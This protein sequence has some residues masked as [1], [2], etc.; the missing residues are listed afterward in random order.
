[1]EEIIRLNKS[2]CK[3]CY[4]CIRNCPVKSIAYRDEQIRIISDECIYCGN[5][6]LVCPQNAKS[7]N[8]D[9]PK[10]KRALQAGEKLYVSLAPSYVAAFPQSG[11][12]KMSAALKALGF[13]HVEETAIGAEQ[14]TRE[15]EKLIQKHRMK[16]I[17]TTACPSVNLLIEKNYPSLIPQMAPVVTPVI[18]HSHMIKK[19][20]GVRAKVVF[21]GPCISKKYECSDP[22]NNH[23]LFAVLTF[24]ELDQ[25]FREEGIDFAK[26][27]RSA[28]ALVN[29]LPRYY[30]TPGGII[31]NLHRDSRRA[32][33]CLSI[34]GVDRCINILDSVV[35]DDL[36]GYFL[37]MN[38]CI[39][40]CLGGP[41]L[42]MMHVGFLKSKDVLTRNVKLHDEA[43][44]ALTEGIAAPFEKRFHTRAGRAVEIDEEDIRRVLAATGKTSPDKEL[45]CG[46]CGYNTCREK[47]IAVLQG[48]ADIRMCIPYM[49]ELAESMSNA[50]VENA[51]TGILIV[52]SAL[53]VEQ[54]NPAAA[55]LLDLNEKSVGQPIGRILPS[56]D[57]EEVL[58]SGKN[59]LNHKQEY[60][61]MHLIVRQTVVLVENSRL[62]FVLLEDIT[63]EEQT[64]EDRRRA[65]AATAAFANEAIDKQ[66]RVVQKIADLLGETTS[67][68]EVALHELTKS[69]AARQGEEIGRP[70]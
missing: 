13:V 40:G 45:N 21:I 61:A 35:R 2:N 31:K 48:K 33:K 37:E 39:G 52:N 25:W 28:R 7:I 22:E 8:S 43:P 29:T 46:C 3:N 69:I 57:F 16:N 44:A 23:A 32:Y 50:V 4:K 59:I 54:F 5:C 27:D 51:P 15:Y 41:A 36:T 17:I 70:D 11:I 66:M 14:V 10:I 24:N 12:V 26:Q 62:L 6:L 49:R 19:I 68:T 1:M 56:A 65:T 55:K 63:R 60:K 47:A 42:R 18:A 20:Y 58:K 38:A 30:P 9:L 64:L 67:E 34:D 53:D